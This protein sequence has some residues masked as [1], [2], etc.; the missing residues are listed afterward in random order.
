MKKEKDKTFW[1]LVLEK[2]DDKYTVGQDIADSI[3]LAV[4]CGLILMVVF[5]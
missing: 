4:L 3:G 5:M 2:H 1:E